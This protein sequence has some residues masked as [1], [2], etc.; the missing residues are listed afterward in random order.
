[1]N[2]IFANKK[3]EKMAN[4]FALSK[5][6]LGNK[7]AIKYHQRLNDIYDV[8]NFDKLKFL[9]G[10]FHLLKGDRN[11]Q[12]ACNLDH[13]YRL[14]F[15]PAANPVPTNEHGTLILTEIKIVEILEIIDYH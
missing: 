14:I 7:R 6:K 1:M 4:N 5:K 10:N 13:P 15:E 8:E 11:G 2:I 12:W 3:L 9:P